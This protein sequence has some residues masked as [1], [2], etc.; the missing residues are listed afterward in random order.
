MASKVLVMDDSK[1]I[2]RMVSLA[3]PS[4]AFEIIQ[5]ADGMEGLER[6]DQHPDL[7]LII[8]DLNMPRLGGLDFLEELRRRPAF[9]SLPVVMLTPESQAP[10]MARAKAFGANG[11]L[12]KPFKPELLL[13]TVVRLLS[14]TKSAA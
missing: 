10:L 12:T 5:A 13:A 2:R 8:S 4:S 9:A 3:L 11:W 1:L 14:T 6:L 7:G